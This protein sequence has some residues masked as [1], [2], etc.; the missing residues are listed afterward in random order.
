[1]F[2]ILN[3]KLKLMNKLFTLLI[4]TVFFASCS[5]LKI[6]HNMDTSI[7]FSQYK[8]YSYHGWDSASTHINKYLQ[9]KIEFAF[10]DELGERG[11]IYDPIGQGDIIISLFLVVNH[12]K[13]TTSYNNYY[14]GSPYGYR[15]GWGYGYGGYGMAYSYGG[16]AYEEHNY[17]YGTLVCDVFD[18]KTKK[19][20]WQGVV[21][22]SVTPSDQGKYI[23]KTISRLMMQF[24][25]EKVKE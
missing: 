18:R 4:A 24:P 11:L 9:N 1:M 6:T 7:D 20:A 15:P 19:L 3:Y 14:A 25:I 21:S 12:E 10:A 22:K 13:S 8:T 16:V 17:Y 23:G 2:L 5:S